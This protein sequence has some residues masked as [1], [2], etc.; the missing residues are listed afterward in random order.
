MTKRLKNEKG[1]ALFIAMMLTLMLSIVGIGIIRSAND[2]IA[3]AGNELNEMKAFYAAEA[4]LERA[5]AAIQTEYEATGIP[6]A[7]MPSETLNVDG[8][9]LTY[10]TI[11]MD[12]A[13]EIITRGSLAG[14]NAVVKPFVIQA[15]A[16]DPIRKTSMVLEETF[17]VATVPLFQF[18]AFYNDD[19]EVSPGSQMLLLGRIHANGDVYLQTGNTLNIDSYLSASGDLHHGPKTGSG[20]AA[21]NGDI[22]IKGIDG[23]Y[24][25]MRDGA[26]WLDADDSYW[27]DSSVSRWGGRIQDEAYGQEVLNLPISVPDSARRIIERATAYGGNSDSYEHDATLKIMDG[28]ARFFNGAAWVDVTAD[29]LADGSL[30][31]TTFY[32]KREETNVTVYDIDVDAFQDSPYYPTNGV[33][34]AGDNRAGL[35][36]TRVYNATTLD[37]GFTLASENPVYT[38][39]NVNSDS[40]THKPMAIITD[41]LTILSGNWDDDPAKAASA[42]KNDRTATA[43]SCYFSFITGNKE[44]GTGGQAYNGGL[45][46][47]PRFL[48]DWTNKNMKFRGSMTCLW[49]SREAVGN[50]ATTYFSE[51]RRNWAFDVALMDPSFAPP[52][53]P[54]VRSFLRT[55]W[56]QANTGFAEAED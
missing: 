5:A 53:S 9:Y 49:E 55:G 54:V 56:R 35:R 45:E 20:L 36:G 38:L 6:P 21:A 44:T 13:K 41:A 18:S 4:G 30:K 22:N 52:G 34:Y 50:Y 24:H 1:L 42:D 43:T 31:E 14:L 12:T 11:E 51:P 40:A 2:E 25:T 8:I 28:T 3:I 7:S 33:V 46:N 32:D 48:E 17:Q 26:A 27:F 10:Y 19:L 39:G 23:A 16:I 37:T 15:T 29:L 47:L